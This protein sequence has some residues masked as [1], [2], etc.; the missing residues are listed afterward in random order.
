MKNSFKV[1]KPITAVEGR[2]RRQHYLEPTVD[3]IS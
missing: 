2:K 1:A 3:E